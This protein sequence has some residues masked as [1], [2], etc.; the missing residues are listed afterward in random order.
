MSYAE[1]H[2]VSLTTSTGGAAT[3]YTLKLVTGRV[4]SVKWAP[5]GIAA[6][7]TVTISTESSGQTILANAA[8][9]AFTKYPRMATHTATGG[10]ALYA[11]G[12][13]AVRD[14]AIAAGERIK[15]VV[16]GGGATKSATLTLVI[17]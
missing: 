14:Y 9:A 10:S 13:V 15:A 6:A 3:A 1:R 16:A 2:A 8:S 12:G 5:T 17:A 7:S 4:I 11:T